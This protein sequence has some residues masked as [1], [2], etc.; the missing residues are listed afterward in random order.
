MYM[1]RNSNTNIKLVTVIGTTLHSVYESR[2]LTNDQLLASTKILF[3]SKRLEGE[4]TIACK[5][6]HIFLKSIRTSLLNPM[7]ICNQ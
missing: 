7:F 4:I 5:N 3:Y 6:L 1:N 2:K